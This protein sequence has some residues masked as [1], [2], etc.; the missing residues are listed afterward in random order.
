MND[1]F[2]L[3]WRRELA[4]GVLAHIDR[5]D[6]VEVI[7]DDWLRASRH[8][9]RAL[10]TLAAQ[11]PVTL[12]GIGLGLAST[13]PVDVGRTEALGRLVGRVRPV[14]WSEHLAFVRAGGIEVG[15][16]AAPPRNPATVAGAVRNLERIAR[17]TGSCPL[18]ENVATLIEPPG[19]SMDEAAWITAVVEQSGAL[20]LLDLHNLH[21]NAT[22]FGFDARAFLGR[23]PI[24]RV[25]A[26]H[27]AGGRWIERFGRRRLLDDHHHD[28]PAA[29]HE[30]LIEV[31]QRAP[32]P[33]DVILERDGRYPPFADLLAELDLARVALARGRALRQ[34]AV[35]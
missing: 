34:E 5:L 10:E 19:S 27:L 16:L 12:H 2:G 7:A 6:L 32:Q 1:R 20:L 3:G 29:V 33:L 25:R 21:A 17:R 13:L 11:L 22:N 35:A 26:V 4:A 24:E 8:D 14:H 23:I 28:V 18:L 9:L 30:L 31:G 15:H